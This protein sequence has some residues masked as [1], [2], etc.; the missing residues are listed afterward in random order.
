M[1]TP[2]RNKEIEERFEDWQIGLDYRAETRCYDS[3]QAQ[4]DYEGCTDPDE[5]AADWF[6]PMTTKGRLL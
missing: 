6:K 2:M 4:Y 5:D 3:K 1:T